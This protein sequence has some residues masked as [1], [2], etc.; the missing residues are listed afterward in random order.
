MLQLINAVE[1]CEKYNRDTDGVT[2]VRIAHDGK[3]YRR[4]VYYKYFSNWSIE[5]VV[6]NGKQHQVNTIKEI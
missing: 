4:K 1:A 3:T 5:Y 6:W 2:F